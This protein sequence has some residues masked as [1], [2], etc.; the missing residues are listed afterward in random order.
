MSYRGLS[1]VSRKAETC[2]VH[3]LLDPVNKSRDDSGK[4]EPCNNAPPTRNDI[5]PLLSPH[6]GSFKFN[7]LPM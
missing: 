1:T 7:Y 4:T 6:L 2:S 5:K 3:Y